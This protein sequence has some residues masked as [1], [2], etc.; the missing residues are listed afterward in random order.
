VLGFGGIVVMDESPEE[1]DRVV[2]KAVDAGINYFDVAPSYGNAEDVLGNALK[3]H[4][5]KVNLACKTLERTAEGARRELEQSLRLLHTDRFDVYQLHGMPNIRELEQAMGP[6]GA[7]ESI[8]DAQERG[9]I[10]FVGITTHFPHVALEAIRRYLFDT[11]MFPISFSSWINSGFGPDVL[12]AAAEKEM[13]VL[14]IKAMALGRL[15]EG[16]ERK[17]AKPWYVPADDPEIVELAL[18]FTLSRDVDS[19]IPPGEIGPF[20]MALSARNITRP[21]DHDEEA[22]LIALA[23]SLEAMFP[24]APIP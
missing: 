7:M 24:I 19:A 15:N 3:R 23:G 5:D 16:C 8:L 12:A 1:A 6:G 10:R 22:R 18:R 11:V 14:A 20:E 13:G 9:I 17:W 4:R 2:S 21:L